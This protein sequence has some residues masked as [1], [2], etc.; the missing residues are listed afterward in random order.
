MKF[1]TFVTIAALV[2]AAASHSSDSDSGDK[3]EAHGHGHEGDTQSCDTKPNELYQYSVMSALRKGVASNGTLIENMLKFGDLGLGTF[4]CLRG[5][6]IVLDGVVY[7]ATSD[8]VVSTPDPAETKTPFMAIT[9]FEPEVETS[10]NITNLAEFGKQIFTWWPE[11]IS[12]RNLFVS[13]RIDGTFSL[14]IRSAAGQ[15]F[16]M[17]TLFATSA[18]QVEWEYKNIKGTIVG[19]H[20]PTYAYAIN[21]VGDHL[22]FISDDR[23]IGGHILEFKSEGEAEVKLA[24]LPAHYIDRPTDGEFTTPFM[25]PEYD[26]D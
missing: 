4:L 7:H 14:R 6:M 22:H 2:G 24:R 1:T 20:T 18:R 23:K 3:D 11:G 5:E 17:E 9:R 21:E 15:D 12:I 26:W 13:I 19:F 8:G 25:G 16:P 10:Q